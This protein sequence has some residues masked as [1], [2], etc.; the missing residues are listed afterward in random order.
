MDSICL[1]YSD[2][3]HQLFQVLKSC[4]WYWFFE[5]FYSSSIQYLLFHIFWVLSLQK[6]AIS[7]GFPNFFWPCHNS[8]STSTSVFLVLRLTFR[9][10]LIWRMNT[11]TGLPSISWTLRSLSACTFWDI[12]SL[13]MQRDSS[14]SSSL[15][16][17]EQY[18]R[19]QR[20]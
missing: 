15:P 2:Q 14:W 10:T 16:L 17:E 13:H 5:S 11:M 12:Y 19:F 9:S 20:S 18:R 7:P 6:L 3:S 8:R 4:P 1:G